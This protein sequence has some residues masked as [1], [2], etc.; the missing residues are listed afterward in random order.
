MTAK[1]FTEIID[2]SMRDKKGLTFFVKGKEIGG[3]VLRLIDDGQAV[4]AKSQ[5]YGKIVIR[6][7]SVDAIAMI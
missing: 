1:M 2:L 7:D 5:Q 4:E 3:L 6:L